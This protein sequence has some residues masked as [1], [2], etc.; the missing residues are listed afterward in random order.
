MKTIQ[1]LLLC[2][3][4][5]VTV[6]SQNTATLGPV[7]NAGF[8][9]SG[10]L[11][12]AE[13]KKVYLTRRTASGIQKDSVVSTDGSFVFKGSVDEPS[14][15]SVSVEGIKGSFPVFMENT[16]I[17][18]EGD[19]NDFVNTRVTGSAEHDQ[20]ANM[21][22]IR[23]KGA[24]PAD[25][26]KKYQTLRENKDT[27]AAKEIESEYMKKAAVM[28][29]EMKQYISS[30]PSSY[31]AVYM[32]AT[33]SYKVDD[34]KKLYEGLRPNHQNSTVGQSIKK[35]LDT[36]A[37]LAI[38]KK[39]PDFEQADVNGKPMKLSSLKGKY[40]LVDFWASWCKPCRE[41]NPNV[42][43]TYQAF[44]QKDF[45]VLGISLDQPGK[46]DDWIK[47]IADDK[48]DWSHVS[49]LKFW[50]NEVALQYGIKSI[51]A[52]ILIDPNGVIVGKNLRGEDLPKK[53]GEII[54]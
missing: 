50:N 43:K 28:Q 7:S 26:M 9:F 32:L 15:H 41:E 49:D 23:R 52:N 22:A 19:V 42:V 51:P 33:G 8:E 3:F 21:D 54:K 2:L 10:K 14:I 48:L 46:K 53:L 5:S 44:K 6:F 30:N 29:E 11:K 36:E 31:A 37:M 1:F 34:L 45:T 40:V 38:G 24:V 25:V 12:G 13:G 17:K 39:A 16:R 20:Y 18:A 4:S 27:I 47:A 35:R